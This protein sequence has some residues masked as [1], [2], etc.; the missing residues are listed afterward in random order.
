M[1]PLD[2]PYRE[3]LTRDVISTYTVGRTKVEKVEFEEILGE[4]KH[5]HEI[6][7][8]CYVGNDEHFFWNN[9]SDASFVTAKLTVPPDR[10][11]KPYYHFE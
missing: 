8:F 2:I 11:L 1:V 6:S 9:Y 3:K 5:C 7:A 4:W 10:N